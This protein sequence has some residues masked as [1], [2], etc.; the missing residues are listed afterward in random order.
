MQRDAAEALRER[1]RA[2]ASDAFE[3]AK[4]LPPAEALRWLDRA[5]RLAGEDPTI[6]LALATCCLALDVPRARKLLETLTEAHDVR[7]AWLALAAAC[8]LGGDPAGAAA[9]LGRALSGHAFDPA[10]QAMADAVA[11]EAGAPGWCGWSGAAPV[12][13]VAGVTLEPRDGWDAAALLHVSAGGAPL[14][15]SPLRLDALRRIEGFVAVEQGLRGWAWRP[16]D[17]AHD[18]M[19]TVQDAR[20]RIVRLTA[21]DQDVEAGSARPLARP[22]AFHLP[23]AALAGL[24]PPLSVRGSDGGDL[25]GSPLDPF[26][27]RRAALAAVRAVARLGGAGPPPPP[28]SAFA[29]VAVSDVPD[30]AFPPASPRPVTVVIP[31]HGGGRIAVEC[32]DAVIAARERGER[33]VAVDDGSP[34][35][36]LSARLRRLARDR[37]IVLIAHDRALG[38]PA[39]ANA[40]IRA[41]AGRDVVL[42]NSDTLAPPGWLAALR[43][44]AYA[45]PGIGTASPLSNDATILSYPRNG[46]PCLDAAGVRRTAEL[47]A[48][49]NGGAVAHVPTTVGFCMYL[50]RDCLDEVGL[51]REDVFAQ[52]YGEEND[53]CLRARTL[54]WR[55][56]AALGAY[57]GHVG[58]AS[59]GAASAH[60]QARNAAVLN[61]LHPGYDAL[62]EAHAAADPLAPARRRM[63][64]LRFRAPARRGPGSV[65]V[66]THDQ[67]GGVERQAAAHC[68]ALAAQGFRAVVLRPVPG[69]AGVEVGEGVRGGFSDLRFA[70]PGELDE[71][72]RLLRATRPARVAIHHMLGHHWSLAGLHERLGATLEVFAHDYALI[73]PRVT[74]LDASARFCGVPEAGVCDACVADGGRADEDDIPVAEYRARSAALLARAQRVAAPSR[75]AAAR[76]E[77]CFPGARAVVAPHEDD[78]ALQEPAPPSPGERV[79]VV[80][81]GAIGLDKGLEVLLAAARDAARRGLPLDFT[82]VGHS[83]DDAR[84]LAAGVFVTGPFRADETQALIEA[85]RP[86]VALLPSIWPETWCFALTDCWRAG[87]PVVAFDL[88]AQA[89]RIRSTGRGALLPPGSPAAAVNAALLACAG[90]SAEG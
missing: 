17:P 57:V 1:A 66:V 80:A 2:S 27:P 25:L 85:Q 28:A 20:G 43:A 10:A 72:V 23:E 8:R 56:A 75:D 35:A 38:F 33:I 14:L 63:D 24:R 62:I 29:P 31:V 78:A 60:L 18:P 11:R 69:G 76:I 89:E 3:R 55:H 6:A 7:E 81:V 44:A 32:L 54:G 49:A 64:A 61:R 88:G 5:W 59:F 19:L 4:G 65:I 68:D 53:F 82:L 46:G 67:A 48:R 45:E 36:A 77:R 42:L 51:L 79:R 12:L 41:A 58:G 84:L 71:L 34:D 9:A 40:G 52:G 50:R 73:C 47:A 83:T 15:G 70:L 22:R 16:A 39:A 37:R 86:D 74:L 90:R 30:R 21:T 26:G 87:L 13:S